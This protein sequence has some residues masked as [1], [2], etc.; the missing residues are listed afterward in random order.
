MT[1]QKVIQMADL[2]NKKVVE[3]NDLVTGVAKMDKVPLKIFELAVSCLDTEN[4]PKDNVVEL[5]KETL[6]SFLNAKEGDTNKH[7]R[8]REALTTLHK[9]SVFEVKE[10][11][12]KGK[13]EFAII[14]PI[15]RTWWNSYGDTV[16]IQFTN[17]IMPYLVDLKQNFTQYLITDIME[18]GSK[19]SIIIYKWL[20]MN[21][22]QFEKYK[23]SS[24]RRK[25]QLNEL[26]NPYI[27]V[28]ELRRMT[29]TEEE[30][31]RVY[32]FFRFVVDAAMKE[33]SE[34]THFEVSY[35][36]VKSGRSV[37]GVRFYIKKKFK[38]PV[39]YK[40]GDS[41][42][43]ESKLEYEKREAELY[44]AAMRSE[45]T[46]MLGANFLIGF[47]DV[48]DV[49]LM[50]SLQQNVYP[51]YDELKSKRGTEGLE[52]H[53]SYVADHKEGYTESKHNVAKYLKVSIE[54]Y[55]QTVKLQDLG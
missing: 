28:E 25:D 21:Y 18:L 17:S 29:N 48:Q 12:E 37:V 8:F 11:S 16:K 1:E 38:A 33:I 31:D 54:K 50:A 30:Y 27:T 3:H 13:W 4:P 6:F 9:Q 23:D 14:S 42:Y 49:T 20:S 36:K 34:H 32:D 51:L 53:L 41:G 22:N 52:K 2:Q 19:Y 39:D 43:E 45:Y 10:R 5:S 24:I 40:S 26:E 35:E 47:N 15:E 46:S 44:T 55:L 7:S